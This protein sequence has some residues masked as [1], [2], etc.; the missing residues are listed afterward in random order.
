MWFSYNNKNNLYVNVFIY[1]LR[2]RA[3]HLLCIYCNLLVSTDLMKE[4]EKKLC[5]IT[6]EQKQ[7]RKTINAYFKTI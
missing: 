7:K 6:M 3:Q 5:K 1:L 2:E 4:R